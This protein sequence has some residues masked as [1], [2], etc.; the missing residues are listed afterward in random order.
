MRM[1]F[2]G[3]VLLVPLAAA[4]GQQAAKIDPEHMLSERFHFTSGEVDQARQ[5]TPI[6]KVQSD[7]EE[8]VI[9]GAIK[10]T[11]KKERLADWVR[12][13]EHFRT[14]AELG[15]THVVKTPAAAAA[16]A[17]VTLDA[18]DLAELQQCRADKC[19]IRLSGEAATRLQ[20]DV[21]WGSASADAEATE[22]VRAMLLGYTTAYLSGGNT[23]VA[24]YDA[25]E[26]RRS[27]A[28]DMHAL[29]AKATNMT[30]LAPEFVACLDGFPASTPSGVEQVFY[31]SA[32]S[33][34]SATILSVHHLMVYRP[35]A[36]E[37]WIADKN[38]YASRYFD[39]GVV[40]IGLYD[41]PQGGGYYALAG[42][43]VKVSQ[44][45]GMAAT[46]MRR[47]IQRSASATVKMYLEWLRESLAQG[48]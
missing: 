4:V 18:T 12:N 2:W 8:L 46:V 14:S 31:W 17:G 6:V 33:A 35:R 19:G 48:L 1:P 47:Q 28:N 10:L 34:G 11:G 29:L 25:P 23:A 37:V 20:R 45:G 13:I 42:S 26:A 9:V 38:V 16:F 27:Y 24:A 36:N 40:A 32:M 30:D 5:G 15:V 22:I 21:K 44:L 41:A 43:R 7:G 39:A 3:I